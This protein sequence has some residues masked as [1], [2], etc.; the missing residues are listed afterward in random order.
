M[1]HSAFNLSSIKRKTFIVWLN[2]VS[3]FHI[4][5]RPHPAE[6]ETESIFV[7]GW[8]EFTFIQWNVSDFCQH[9]DNS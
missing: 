8:S 2:F 6:Y 3:F 1:K 7:T 5:H 4:R 9:R